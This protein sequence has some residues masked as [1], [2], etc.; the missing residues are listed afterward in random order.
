MS[1]CSQKLD[2]RCNRWQRPLAVNTSQPDE[3]T[4]QRVIQSPA[5]GADA[6]AKAVPANQGHRN[7]EEVAN[8][9]LR[10][11]A[12]QHD[13]ELR[14]HVRKRLHRLRKLAAGDNVRLVDEELDAWCGNATCG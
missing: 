3:F 9:D 14:F 1:S 2:T 7:I 6:L 13:N 10:Q 4:W 12:R 5:D 8:A 11:G